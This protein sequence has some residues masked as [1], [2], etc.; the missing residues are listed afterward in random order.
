MDGK[1]DGRGKNDKYVHMFFDK[2]SSES[3]GQ[4]NESRLPACIMNERMERI[5][6]R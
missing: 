6:E 5:I 1:I 4:I 3:T 2:L